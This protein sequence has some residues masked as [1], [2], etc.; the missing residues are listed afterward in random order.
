MLGPVEG[1]RIVELGAGIGRFT[2]ELACT[3]RSV[4]AVDFMEHLIDENRARNGAC[5]NVSWLAADATTMVGTPSYR[6]AP[7]VNF[8]DAWFLTLLA[9]VISRFEILHVCCDSALRILSRWALLSQE[10]PA[11]SQDIVF[12]NWLLMYLSDAEVAKLA[13]DALHWVRC[14]QQHPAPAHTAFCALAHYT[15]DRESIL[16]SVGI[17]G[18]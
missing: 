10:L 7:H 1:Q 15:D 3:A 18:G 11:D 14:K 16:I 6:Q 13:A 2:G 8:T 17:I 9:S 4:L 12:S 5:G